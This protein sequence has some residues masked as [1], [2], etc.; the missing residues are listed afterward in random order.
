MHVEFETSEWRC[1]IGSWIFPSGVQR[2]KQ[3]G[4]INLGV[5]SISVIFKTTKLDEISKGGV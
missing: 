1:W 3:P 2:S 4:D 5:V